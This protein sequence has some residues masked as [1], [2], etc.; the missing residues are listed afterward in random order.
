LFHMDYYVRYSHA[1]PRGVR[2][3]LTV[4]IISPLAKNQLMEELNEE[5]EDC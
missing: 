3:E 1:Y 5:N 4:R 2:S